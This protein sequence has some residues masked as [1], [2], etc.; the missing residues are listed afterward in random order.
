MLFKRWITAIILIPFLLLILLK[1]SPLAF[2][3][4]VAALAVVSMKEYFTIVSSCDFFSDSP[5]KNI[6]NDSS[7][8]PNDF[9]VSESNSSVKRSDVAEKSL[10]VPLPDDGPTVSGVLSHHDVIPLKIRLCGYAVSILIILAA[11]KSCPEMIILLTTFNIMFVFMAVMGDFSVESNPLDN[12]AKE[13]QGVIYIPVFLS[14]LVLIRN[15]VGGSIWIIWLWLIIAASDTGAYY[16]GT[17][18]GKR[19]LAPKISPH[20]TIEGAAGGIVAAVVVGIIFGLIYIPG[21][22]FLPLF[23]FAFAAAA[24]GQTGDLFESALKRKGCIKD[25]GIILPG[26]GGLLDRIDGLIFAAPI[27]FLFKFFLANL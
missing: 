20:K 16:C 26:H 1:G 19:S 4:L 25:S 11:H 8:S 14:F 6:R 9:P 21:I 2:S 23:F 5:G 12:A 17:Y 22:S 10:H 24:A 27:A 18:Y 13:I 3:L 15:S 7:P